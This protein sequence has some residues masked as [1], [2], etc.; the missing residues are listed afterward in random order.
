M[1]TCQKNRE[2]VS[3]VGNMVEALF[4]EVSILPLSDGAKA[5][6]VT[7]MLGD[8]FKRDGQTIYFHCPSGL[9]EAVVAA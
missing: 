2:I 1:E 6:L 3:S 7:I 4:D 9:S 8:I 5:A